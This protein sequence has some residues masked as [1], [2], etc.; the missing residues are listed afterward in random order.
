MN[1]T[2]LRPAPRL[3]LLLLS[4]AALFVLGVPLVPGPGLPRAAAQ[5]GADAALDLTTEIDGHL[6]EAR[7]QLD[8]ILAVEG[9]RTVENTLEPYNELTIQLNLASAKASLMENTHPDAEVRT[10]AETANQE[11]SALATELSLNRDL[12]EAFASLDLSGADDLTR[13]LG[14]R[15][16]RDY[17][18][19]GV[20]KDEETRTRIAGLRDELVAIGQEFG[21]NI[22]DGRRSIQVDSAEDLAG[23]P[24]DYIAAHAPDEAGKIT[25]TTDYPDY[26]PF[27]EYA[28]DGELRRRLYI[29]FNNRGY[30]ENL[31][32]FQ[33]MME[34]RYELAQ[35]LGYDSWAHYITEDKMSKT[36]ATVQAFIDQ[37]NAAARPAA[38]RDLA[39]IL[40]RKRKDDPTADTIADYEKSY[41]SNLVKAENYD[42][43]TQVLRAYYNYPEVKAGILD[44]CS[45]LFGVEFKRILDAPVWE[46][47]VERYEMYEN[48]ELKGRFYLDMHPRDGKYSHA[49]QFPLVTGI[50]GRQVPEAVL[51]CNF[52]APDADGLALMA[53]DQVETFLHEFGH[54]LHTL[55]GGHHRW[56]D[57][58]GIATEWD[59]VEA[60]SQMLEEWAKDVS[61]LQTFAHHYQ[62]GE[63]VP[64]ELVRNMKRAETFGNG[65]YV[66][67]Q[68][69]Y[70]ALSLNA[71]NRLPSEVDMD[72]L[73]QELLAKYSSFEY[74]PGTHMYASFG[75][76]NGYSAMYYTY[77]WSLVIAKDLFSKFDTSDMLNSG[78]ATEY[79]K[80]VLDP[81]GTEDAS[82]LIEGFLG[83]PYGFESFSRWLNGNEG[84]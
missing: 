74:V 53:H 61:S 17:R 43:D 38:E 78:I 22:R 35:A 11:V 40:E 16:L 14:E 58:S 44:L 25:I 68:N 12:Y 49:A 71:H 6:V 54:L 72:A 27:M 1:P 39:E 37:L 3:R 60:P 82:D 51:V 48:G 69:Y 62:T 21:R 42:F 45:T 10:T 41:Y 75:H 73:V 9:E 64:A 70:T 15:L 33:R 2:S 65:I 24:E 57:Q 59:F 5:S 79:R 56:A 8:I 13:R 80:R 7:R 28:K 76:L 55:F 31:E 81:G 77:M 36:P 30:P 26:I 34:K 20:D 63:P 83:R 29:E 32:V 84:S 19:A 23:L 50:E 52:P 66:T 18:R 47:S 4:G 67:Q 46:P